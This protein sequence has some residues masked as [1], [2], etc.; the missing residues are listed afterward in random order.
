MRAWRDC[1]ESARD[2]VSKNQASCSDSY[3]V[4]VR[5]APSPCTKLLLSVCV[6]CPKT[7]CSNSWR[8]RQSEVRCLSQDSHDIIYCISS[9]EISSAHLQQHRAMWRGVQSAVRQRQHQSRK[10]ALARRAS[11]PALVIVV[12]LHTWSSCYGGGGGVV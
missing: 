10:A 5:P 7:H 12:L 1:I 3:T 8:P 2:K 11:A 6:V 9:A 4:W